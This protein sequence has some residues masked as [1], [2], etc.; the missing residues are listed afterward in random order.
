MVNSTTIRRV[1]VQNPDGSTTTT[2]TSTVDAA[3]SP[4][5]PAPSPERVVFTAS[6]GRSVSSG[7]NLDDVPPAERIVV[8]QVLEGVELVQ[9]V[10]KFG[11]RVSSIAKML[12]PKD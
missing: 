11:R 2:E 3:P 6:D 12:F 7:V 10:L 8:E 4:A 9:Q 1:T 5:P